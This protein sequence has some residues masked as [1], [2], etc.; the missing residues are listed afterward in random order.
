MRNGTFKDY[1]FPTFHADVT[2]A[3]SVF[4]CNYDAAATLVVENL[5]PRAKPVPMTKNRAII[6]FSCYEY[7]KVN[8]MNAYNE[9]A[10]AIPIAVNA[11]KGRKILPLVNPK[12]ADH[13]VYYIC[14]MPVTSEENMIRGHE[15]WGLPK[16]T[17]RIDITQESGVC[18]GKAFDPEESE[19]YLTLQCP[20]KGKAKAFDVSYYIYSKFNGEVCQSQMNFAQTF[21]VN[22]RLA[23]LLKMGKQITEKSA[24]IKL[25]TSSSADFLKELKIESIPFQTRYAEHMRGCIDLPN[26]NAPDWLKELNQ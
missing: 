7:K 20:M 6:A 16:T 4:M 22:T 21:N 11:K 12:P 5:H 26:S 15:I 9:I 23:L 17:E 8:G 14:G 1:L 19:P 13:F 10:M 2:C 25:G 24:A 18:T 3:M